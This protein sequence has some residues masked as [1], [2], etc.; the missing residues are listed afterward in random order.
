MAGYKNFE[1]EEYSDVSSEG[2]IKV[3]W[4]IRIWVNI[5]AYLSGPGIQASKMSNFKEISAIITNW[6]CILVNQ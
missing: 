4:S 6:F 3:M 1:M 5:L 2:H